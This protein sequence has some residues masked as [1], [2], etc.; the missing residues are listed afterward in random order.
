MKIKEKSIEERFK[1][2]SEREH[3]LARPGM[4][5]GSIKYEEAQ[6]FLNK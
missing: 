5:V 2:M 1:S 4:W 3:I 6:Q